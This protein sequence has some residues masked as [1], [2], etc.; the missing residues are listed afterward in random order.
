MSR[1]EEPVF[2]FWDT[3]TTGVSPK[4][5]SIIEISMIRVP[6][7][8]ADNTHFEQFTMRLR[9]PRTEFPRAT[10]VH[11]LNYHEH[12]AHCASFE[13]ACPAILSF[14]RQYSPRPVVLVAHNCRFD[15]SM[16]LG[17]LQRV[18]R[19]LPHEVRFACSLKMFRDAR[20]AGELELAQCNL[21]AVYQKVLGRPLCG[22]HGAFADSLGII[23]VLQHLA[24]HSLGWQD[25]QS[26]YLRL[27]RQAGLYS[28]PG[29][30]HDTGG[31]LHDTG[32]EQVQGL[33]NEL[34]GLCMEQPPPYSPL[35][36]PPPTEEALEQD[37]AVSVAVAQGCECHCGLQ[38][39]KYVVKKLSSSNIG[40]QFRCCP[41]AGTRQCSFFQWVDENGLMAGIDSRRCRCGEPAIAR[42]VTKQSPNKGREFYTCSKPK[43]CGYFEWK[44]DRK[45]GECD[46]SWKRLVDEFISN[47]SVEHQ[48]LQ[49]P[50]SLSKEERQV[51]HQYC[52][53]WNQALACKGQQIIH[54]SLGQ[55]PSRVLC[56]SFRSECY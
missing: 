12:L 6:I 51:V 23:Q 8:D 29:A 48:I 53:Q 26:P 1:N 56:L 21:G 43:S 44:S 35:P 52:D 34:T 22:A 25:D 10:A 3:E 47:A 4:H 28:I 9:P 13:E 27:A 46:E 40:R 45:S 38:A 18:G 54:K 14:M 50:P 19:H 55:E 16:L 20:K 37:E 31:A 36:E 32:D 7:E 42:T 17:E 49:L 41:S 24:S 30:L 2:I 11:G 33:C 39:A 15:A 5:D